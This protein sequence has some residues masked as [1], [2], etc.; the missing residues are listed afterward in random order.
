ME[1]KD[2]AREEPFP[3]GLKTANLETLSLKA[4]LA[5][6]PGECNRLFHACIDYGFFYLNLEGTELSEE[7]MSI[8]SR[9]FALSQSVFDLPAEEKKKYDLKDKG[10]FFG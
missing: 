3:K 8:V 6:E 2:F 5:L 10:L 7:L 1:V 9:L 4:I